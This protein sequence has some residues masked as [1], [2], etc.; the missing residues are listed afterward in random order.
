MS[1]NFHM[2]SSNF[3]DK[4]RTSYYEHI[5]QHAEDCLE[6]NHDYLDNADNPHLW[7]IHDSIHAIT[8]Y[9]FSTIDACIILLVSDNYDHHFSEFGGPEPSDFKETPK[10]HAVIHS[11]AAAA[12]YEDIAQA[13]N[14]LIKQ[15]HLMK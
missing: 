9:D 15:E 12:Y 4:F 5:Q 2:L 1:L 11:L 10:S 3:P 8:E 14:S 13:C 6:Y 7:D